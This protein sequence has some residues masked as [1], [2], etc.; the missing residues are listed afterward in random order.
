N[1]WKN[2]GARLR[3]W[4][5]GSAKETQEGVVMLDMGEYTYA[6]EMPGGVLPIVLSASF[7]AHSGAGGA[8][9]SGG[10]GLQGGDADQHSE[11][12]TPTDGKAAGSRAGAGDG[13]AASQRSA[14]AASSAGGPGAIERASQR[15]PQQ[16]ESQPDRLHIYQVL[17]PMLQ[18]R[19][20]HF[21]AAVRLSPPDWATLDRAYFDAPGTLSLPL[22]SDEIVPPGLPDVAVT[23]VFASVEGAKMFTAMNR[24]TARYAHDEIVAVMRSVLLQM[25][26]GYLVRAQDGDLK[27][28][29][30]FCSPE[31]AVLWC[32]AVQ[33]C[34]MYAEWSD[35]VLR[36]WPEVRDVDDDALLFRGPR[37][38]MGLCEGIPGSVMPDFSGRA[39]YA[40]TSIN[41]AARYMDA[42]AHG[43]HVSCD[44]ALARKVLALLPKQLPQAQQQLQR[45][46]PR[47][48]SSTIAEGG[49]DAAGGTQSPRGPAAGAR[50]PRG[51]IGVHAA[52]T[53][54]IPGSPRRTIGRTALYAEDAAPAPTPTPAPAAGSAGFPRPGGGSVIPTRVAPGAPW[55]PPSWAPPRRSISAASPL[56]PL[57]SSHQATPGMGGALPPPL[58]LPPLAL[59]AGSREGSA[60]N[61]VHL[62]APPSANGAALRGGTHVSSVC[63]GSSSPLGRVP[64]GGA[65]SP[66]DASFSRLSSPAALA[67]VPTDGGGG[68]CFDDGRGGA[69]SASSS[70][71]FAVRSAAD[72]SGVRFSLVGGSSGDNGDE[73]RP[74]HSSADTFSFLAPSPGDCGLGGEGCMGSS[75]SWRHASQAASSLPE[76]AGA[77]AAGVVGAEGVGTC[78]ARGSSLPPHASTHPSGGVAGIGFGGVRGGSG[79]G[80][81]GAGS[82]ASTGPS[83]PLRTVASGAEEVIALHIGHY[84]FKG[85]LEIIEMAHF[86]VARLQNRVF[87]SDGPRGKGFL[88]RPGR[89]VVGTAAAP[90]LCIVDA[91]R[92]RHNVLHGAR[93]ATGPRGAGGSGASGGGP[94]M[95]QTWSVRSFARHSLP[96]GA[97]YSSPSSNAAPP[98]ATAGT[99]S[100][101]AMPASPGASARFLGSSRSSRGL[102]H[103]RGGVE[104]TV[105]GGREGSQRGGLGRGGDA[106]ALALG[107]DLEGG[108]V[109]GRIEEE[110]GGE[111]VESAV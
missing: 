45:P 4:F 103:D 26:G 41:Q 24:R 25:P 79:F 82:K 72:A 73:D 43:G 44:I 36:H 56:P 60:G 10:V 68:S 74:A 90:L 34:V 13:G 96:W 39:D 95:F 81:S 21:G 15:F 2:A 1:P 87:P 109:G 97:S 108:G 110:P 69:A 99:A 19:G 33:E 42:A 9:R 86:T 93:P 23:M 12:S 58:P 89:G 91:Y 57:S 63:G 111:V 102:N 47:H 6:A 14:A 67:E 38:K 70:A 66:R 107:G 37:L 29:V 59:N 98:A 11:R 35:A 20:R 48:Q 18:A 88:V 106:A 50:S 31:L 100:A 62:A 55:A 51:S 46:A 54:S 94:P 5:T 30:A 3:S 101:S 104:M 105:E 84:S 17:P 49:P 80:A 85:S 83:S 40:G 16:R 32:V 53:G 76:W 28:M 61:L 77:A 78:D 71:A 8:G 7:L 22:S 64:A 92:R 52:G 75:S 65:R 27:Y